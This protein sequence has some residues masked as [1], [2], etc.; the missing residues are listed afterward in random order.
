MDDAV[1]LIDAVDSVWALLTLFLV[2][3]YALMWKFGGEL[4]KNS[5]ESKALAQDSND[6]AKKISR[7]IITNHGSKNLGDAI[8]RLTEQSWKHD[9]KLE[10]VSR[11]TH[12]LD[13]SMEGVQSAILRQAAQL[14]LAIRQIKTYIS[15]NA[16]LMAYGRRNM[17]EQLEL[18]EGK[19][20]EQAE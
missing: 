16:D 13:D 19:K 5:R 15:D 11:K 3:I 2:G 10:I 9:E 14:D 18:E 4:L 20:N 12:E 1:R 17:D 6:E 8:D 7:N